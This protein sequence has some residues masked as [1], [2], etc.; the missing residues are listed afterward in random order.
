MRIKLHPACTR[1]AR[2]RSRL[3]SRCQACWRC[4]APVEFNSVTSLD[5][6]CL[7]VLTTD[8]TVLVLYFSREKISYFFHSTNASRLERP[9][10]L[11]EAL[12]PPYLATRLRKDLQIEDY[13]RTRFFFSVHPGTLSACQLLS[14]T[15]S[16]FPRLPSSSCLSQT[17]VIARM[18]ERKRL[19]HA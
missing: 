12:E 14:T 9:I 13:C 1:T 6:M 7:T 11:S 8:Y 16:R 4:G 10:I 17:R 15:A 19:T 2:K 5:H 3:S 18:S